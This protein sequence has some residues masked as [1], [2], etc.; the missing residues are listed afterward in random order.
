M[1]S[2]LIVRA[3]WCTT[4]G[5]GTG[6][7]LTIPHALCKAHLLRELLYAKELT[8]HQ[9][10]QTMTDFLLSANQLSWAA[11]RSGKCFS[12]TDIAAFTTPYNALVDEGEILHREV[13]LPIGKGGRAKQSAAC[14]LLRRF[15]KHTDA[16]CC[17]F[18]IS[19]YRSPTTSPNGPYACQ[20]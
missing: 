20:R 7:N 9:W 13:E 8:G 16:S 5:H 15:R 2:C 10:P 12:K 17:S 1:T 14:N 6:G 4:A 11:R 18:A 19:S 3:Y